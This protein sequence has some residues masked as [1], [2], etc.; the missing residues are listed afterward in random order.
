MAVRA[1]GR[2][3]RNRL[4][5]LLTAAFRDDPL[6]LWMYE[7][8]ARYERRS[9]HAWRAL[10]AW[11]LAHGIVLTDPERRGVA[12]W[13]PPRPPGSGDRAGGLA[14]GLRLALALG[15]RVTAV[16]RG[17]ADVQRLRPAAAHWYLAAL[18]TDEAYR[19]RGIASALLRA[20]LSRCDAEDHIAWLECSR[21]RNLS[22]YASHG[23]EVV[24][25]LH[26]RP[27]GP[28]LWVMRRLPRPGLP[29][30]PERE[31]RQ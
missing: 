15:R 25:R 1:T 10:V 30:G 4:C 11:R 21:E 6:K 24:R 20:V 12:L 23:F 19:R 17:L 16:D 22:L 14:L 8:R 18:A 3:D 31:P 26:I 28:P 27:D 5:A 9:P 2:A 7:S 29:A 13:D